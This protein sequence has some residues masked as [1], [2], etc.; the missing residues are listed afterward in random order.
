MPYELADRLARVTPPDIEGEVFPGVLSNHAF[1]AAV[2]LLAQ[3]IATRAQ[4]VNGLGLTADDQVQ[5]D[6]MAAHYAGLT[7]A[8]KDAF[9]GKLEA[10]GVL[11]ERGM[12]S[13]AFYKNQL[14]LT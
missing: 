11:L 1:S 14:G 8:K 4:V 9:H 12:I 7:N 13:K 2:Y 5:L 3:G 6:Q 10:L